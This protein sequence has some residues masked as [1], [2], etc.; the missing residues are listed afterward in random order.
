MATARGMAMTTA[1]SKAA[2][3]IKTQQ[4]RKRRS[5]RGG[6]QK[7]KGKAHSPLVAMNGL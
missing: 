1:K 2:T 4:Q 5:L 7:D 6:N 3:R